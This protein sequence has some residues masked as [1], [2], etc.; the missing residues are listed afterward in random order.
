MILLTGCGFKGAVEWTGTQEG[1]ETSW[2]REPVTVAVVICRKGNSVFVRS[3]LNGW[4][5]WTRLLATSAS[6]LSSVETPCAGIGR[7]CTLTETVLAFHL[8]N[9]ST[10]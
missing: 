10:M 3:T 4:R 1:L 8:K 6:T 2:L 5:V 9:L 7:K